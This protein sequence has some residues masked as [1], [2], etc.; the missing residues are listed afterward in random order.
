M[1]SA[2]NFETD[3]SHTLRVVASDSG[4]PPLTITCTVQ[5]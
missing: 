2:L 4:T 1:K 5:V 3:P